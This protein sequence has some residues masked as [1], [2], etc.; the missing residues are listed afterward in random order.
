[1]MQTQRDTLT[2]ESLDKES[3][4]GLGE[5]E[6]DFIVSEGLFHRRAWSHM[7]DI[8][9]MQWKLQIYTRYKENLA[10]N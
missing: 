1:M 7:A 2:R 8:G 6:C 5:R 9:E 3:F 4:G 10:N